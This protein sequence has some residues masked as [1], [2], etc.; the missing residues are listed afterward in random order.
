MGVGALM[1]LGSGCGESRSAPPAA[2]AAVP[3]E[4]VTV[5]A[6]DV[7]VSLDAVG[8]LAADQ[9][10]QI[11]SE[12]AGRVREITFVEGARVNVGDVLLS[13]EDEK[14]QAQLR[15]AEA[16]VTSA[17]VRLRL[18]R[19][20]YERAA[21][22][23]QQGVAAQQE[24]DDARAARDEADAA[25]GQAVAARALAQE[26]VRESVVR[27]P[28]AGVVGARRVDVGAYLKEGQA[29]TTLADVDPIEVEFTVPEKYVAQLHV[30]QPVET[31]VASFS[32]RAFTGTVTFIDPQVDAVNRVARLKAAVPNPGA[33]LRPGQ[34]AT[35]R[36]YLD[37]HLGVPVVPEEAIVPEGERLLV[38]AVEDSTAR[39]R[40]IEIGVRLAGHAEVLSGLQAGD[41]VVRLG[42]EKL[43]P[44]AAN[45][46]AVHEGKA[47]ETGARR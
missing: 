6:Q 11:A 36:L 19:Q 44:D 1:A 34:F 24:Y 38:Y 14:L 8:T 12:R 22:L 46:V 20:R 9:L 40:P 3:V 32:D 10:V 33:A 21:T 45:L 17:E 42:H 30:E 27:A 41:V 2:P 37:R 39:A 15:V 4:V 31:R 23:R 47:P 13:L 18:A 7:D 28:F 26:Q 25:L 5:Q 29:I 35:V 16:N 43:R